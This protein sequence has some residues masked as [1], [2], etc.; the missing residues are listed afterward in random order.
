MVK[1][2]KATLTGASHTGVQTGGAVQLSAQN[3]G[4]WG[5]EGP[6]LP[7]GVLAVL[8]TRRQRQTR[9]TQS[10]LLLLIC[11]RKALIFLFPNFSA[12][13]LKEEKLIIN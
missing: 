3:C 2:T 9:H 12:M 10:P 7:A 11:S 5:V 13:I 4:G 6:R 1:M 8:P